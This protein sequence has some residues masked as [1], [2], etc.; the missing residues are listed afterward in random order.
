MLI[1]SYVQ[2]VDELV[3]DHHGVQRLDTL[4]YF[5]AGGGAYTQPR[6]VKATHPQ[7]TITVAEIDP[8]V[9][10]VARQKLYLDSNGMTIVHRDARMALQHS[11]PGSFDVIVT[12]AFHDIAVP[13][14]LVTRSSWRWLH[15]D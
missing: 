11:V 1:S 12:D 8:V 14:H 15:R 2:L 10:E 13:Y 4:S 7:A 3:I 9:T 6:A 5:F